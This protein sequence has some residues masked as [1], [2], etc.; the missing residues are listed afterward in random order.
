MHSTQKALIAVI[1]FL[2]RFRY[3]LIIR[4]SGFRN[5]RVVSGRATS[6]DGGVES[7]VWVW[8][9]VS[10]LSEGAFGCLLLGEGVGDDF[11]LLRR[12]EVEESLL[13]FQ[14]LLNLGSD[15]LDQHPARAID[16]LAHEPTP[17]H[18]SILVF[19]EVGFESQFEVDATTCAAV[20]GC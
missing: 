13:I 1:G 19:F 11:L 10:F 4:P 3:F 7:W 18:S 6:C 16:E 17:P 12:G 9:G 14:C 8:L 5:P 20:T 2:I 15:I